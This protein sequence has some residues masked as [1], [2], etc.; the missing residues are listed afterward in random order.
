MHRS[1]QQA[2]RVRR[3]GCTPQPSAPGPSRWPRSV[4]RSKSMSALSS[5]ILRSESI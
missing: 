5:V 4:P 3:Y 1:P 2:I